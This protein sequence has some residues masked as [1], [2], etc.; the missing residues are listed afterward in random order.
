MLRWLVD[1]S[2]QSCWI[3]WGCCKNICYD[4]AGH[5]EMASRIFNSEL[6]DLLRRLW[7]YLLWFC[8]LCWDG[9]QNIK[10][11]PPAIH[12]PWQHP[13]SLLESGVSSGSR[14]IEHPVFW[15][16]R[17][18]LTEWAAIPISNLG[19]YPLF[20]KK[21]VTC[22][23]E[24][25]VLLYTNSA[26]GKRDTQVDILFKDLVDAFGLSVCLGVVGGW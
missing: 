15:V 11:M 19:W 26:S 2:I 3:Y 18:Y 4:S 12:S 13:I 6:P 16:Y 10:F 8:Q 22:I 23:V 7:K 21:G 1:Y 14:D 20:A 24:C 5:V 9:Q 25:R 17:Q